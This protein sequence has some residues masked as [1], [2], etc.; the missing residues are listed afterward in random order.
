MPLE[1]LKKLEQL[2]KDFESIQYAYSTKTAIQFENF[3][4][5]LH[6]ISN[7]Y[8]GLEE[9]VNEV[10]EF[11]STL[12]ERLI[13]LTKQ[14]ASLEADLHDLRESITSADNRSNQDSD[15]ANQIGEG[16]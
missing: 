15:A 13:E 10:A 8:M 4:H 14:L 11:G 3:S 9:K 1:R 2:T 6:S 12:E 5:K 7:L 16:A